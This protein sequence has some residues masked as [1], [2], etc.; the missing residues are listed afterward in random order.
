MAAIG[1]KDHWCSVDRAGFGLQLAEE[2]LIEAAE[3]LRGI[4]EFLHLHAIIPDEGSH[5][6][7]R[8]GPIH[9]PAVEFREKRPFHERLE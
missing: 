8:S 4:G 5:L 3:R 2:K 7:G 9:P 6:R 1:G